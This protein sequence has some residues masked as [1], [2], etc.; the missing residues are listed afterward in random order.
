[1]TRSTRPAHK[2]WFAIWIELDGGDIRE[3]CTF[4]DGRVKALERRPAGGYSRW[5]RRQNGSR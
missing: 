2:H 4:G 1:M 5:R 3:R